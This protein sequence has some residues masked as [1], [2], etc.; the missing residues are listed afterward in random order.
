MLCKNPG[1]GISGGRRTSPLGEKL[2]EER[3]G[4]G[5][6]I[7]FGGQWFIGCEGVFMK[8][9]QIKGGDIESS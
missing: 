9:F 1:R 6:I 5:K 2:N 3:E 4:K 7:K 8:N